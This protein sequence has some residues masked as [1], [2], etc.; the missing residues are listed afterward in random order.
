VFLFLFWFYILFFY[1]YSIKLLTY[2]NN[3]TFIAK[4]VPT[5]DIDGVNKVFTLLNTPDYIDDIFIDGAIYTSFSISWTQ[6]TLTDAPTLS[7]FV[8]YTL[9]STTVQEDTTITWGVVKSQI[10][11]NLWQTSDS[12]NFSN[13]VLD[14]AMNS[15]VSDIYRG[16]VQSVLDKEK[17]RAWKL[18]FI[19]WFTKFRYIPSTKLTAELNLWDTI[20]EMNTTNLLTAWVVNIGWDVITYTSKTDTQIEG[21]T[22]QTI[23]HL[24]TDVVL[25]LYKMP[26]EMDKPTKVEFVVKN[27]DN[28][29]LPLPLDNTD[30]YRKYYQ[31]TRVWNDIYLKV[32][33]LETDQI[34]EVDYI[35]RHTNVTDNNT[36]FPITDQ[37]WLSVVANIVSWTLG[38]WYKLPDS[39]EQ[40]SIW[41]TNLQSMFQYFTNEE[42]VIKQ[43]I[44]PQSYWYRSIR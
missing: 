18:W 25:P 41:Y 16:R 43:S 35:K 6:I 31:M 4:E 28:K 21:V 27:T 8:D 15:L 42:N 7:I 1:N 34:V 2:Y 32:I 37:Y 19:D 3:M 26:T 33:W 24:I 12:T 38:L 23:K 29:K 20:A 40:L 5:W 36:L 30:L 39:K 14:A 13:N 10:L 22:W 44:K 9:A 17:Y 11:T